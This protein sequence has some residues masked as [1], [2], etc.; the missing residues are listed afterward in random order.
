MYEIIKQNILFKSVTS[1]SSNHASDTRLT[2]SMATLIF[3]H[4]TETLFYTE[5]EEFSLCSL[6]LTLSL[7]VSVSLSVYLCLSLS[8]VGKMISKIK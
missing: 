8:K 7:S 5:T 1:E 3:C 6:S 2:T 4:H